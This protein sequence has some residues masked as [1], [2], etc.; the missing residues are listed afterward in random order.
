MIAPVLTVTLPDLPGILAEFGRMD[1]AFDNQRPMLEEAR[2]EFEYVVSEKFASEGP[3]WRA[4]ESIT[5]RKRA[6]Q[7]HTGGILHEEGRLEASYM[8]GE[9]GHYEDWGNDFVETGSALRWAEPHEKGFSNRGTIPATDDSPRLKMRG[10][11]V[12]PR[13]LFQ[14]FSEGERRIADRYERSVLQMLGL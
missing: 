4:R 3:G 13:S 1:E 12:G 9:D 5:N 11:F 7:G 14:D 6:A 8:S 10:Q 2:E